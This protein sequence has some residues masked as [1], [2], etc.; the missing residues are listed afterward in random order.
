MARSLVER[1]LI[2]LGD[3]LKD[4]RADLRVADEQLAQ[5]AEEAEESRLRSLVSETPLAEREYRDAQRHADAMERHRR[6]LSV[7][8]AR[9]EQAQDELLDRLLVEPE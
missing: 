1:R 5:L 7:E 8:I 3:R 4:L 9:L 2:E 6:E